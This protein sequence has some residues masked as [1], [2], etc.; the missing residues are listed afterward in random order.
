MVDELTELEV[1]ATGGNASGYAADTAREQLPN[2]LLARHRIDDPKLLADLQT[3]FHRIAFLN[4]I[5]VDEY[6]REKGVGSSLLDRFI[7]D[8]C[9]DGAE[10]VL[11]MADACETQ[12]E[13]FNLVSWYEARGFVVLAQSPSGPLMLLDLA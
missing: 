11:L 6:F 4:N 8:A 5:N 7:S 3:R 10:A 1:S 2:W 13:G 9:D 12:R